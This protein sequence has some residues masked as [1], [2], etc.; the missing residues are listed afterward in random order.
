M[1]TAELQEIAKLLMQDVRD[2]LQSKSSGFP[3]SLMEKMEKLLEHTYYDMQ[4]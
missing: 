1:N 4:S 3:P 2:D